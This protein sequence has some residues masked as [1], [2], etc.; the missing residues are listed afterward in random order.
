LTVALALGG[1][2]ALAGLCTATF[3]GM[4]ASTQ[5]GGGLV[6]LAVWFGFAAWIRRGPTSPTTAWGQDVS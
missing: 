3:A 1:R 4:A 6:I 5:Y 2:F